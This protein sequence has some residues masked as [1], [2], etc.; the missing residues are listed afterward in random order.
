MGPLHIVDAKFAQTTLAHYYSNA[1]GPKTLSHRVVNAN[2][3]INNTE[4]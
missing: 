3:K 4:D 1:L 2:K